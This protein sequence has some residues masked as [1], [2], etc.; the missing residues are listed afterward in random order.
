VVSHDAEHEAARFLGG[1]MTARARE[2]FSRHLLTCA[3]CWDEVERGRMGRALAESVRTA[4][5]VELRD[6]VRGLVEAESLAGTHAAASRRSRRRW[7]VPVGVPVAAA[8]AMVVVVVVA[9]RGPTEPPALR[10]AVADFA[11]QELPG[12]HL[13]SRQAPDLTVLNLRPMGAGAGTYA[14]LEVDGYAYQDPA[15]RRIV[16]YLSDDPFPEAPGAQLLAGPDGPWVAHRDG[17]V[18]LCARYPHALL[19]VGQDDDLVR[20]TADQLG[21]L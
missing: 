13:P 14:G 3:P 15:G 21:V 8:A 16:L 4:A 19:V 11:A 20:T 5:P 6:R 17:V 18:V 9:G 1:D 7:V 12:A 10:E 2:A